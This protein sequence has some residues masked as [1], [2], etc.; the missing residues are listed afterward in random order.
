MRNEVIEAYVTDVLRR[1]PGKDRTGIGFELRGLLTDMLAEREHPDDDATVLAMLREFGT[2]AEVAERYRPPGLVII[3][4]SES[5]TFARWA[6][7]GVLLQWALTLPQVFGDLRL[8]TWWFSWGLGALWWPGFLVMAYL[9]QAAV[10]QRGW[11]TPSAW[12]P[13]TFDPERVNRG[14]L[15]MGL[16]AFA[17]GVAL[18]CALPWI[19]PALPAPLAQVLAF[20]ADFLRSRAWWALPLW[21]ASFATLAWVYARG[22][23]S[24]LTRHL[25][26]LTS[27]AFIALMA[28]WIAAGPI[29]LA[30]ATNDGARGA[31]VLVIAILLVDVVV[32]AVREAVR[33]RTPR[34]TTG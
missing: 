26:M 2:P 25:D 18:M 27:L 19:T 10:R 5:R 23:W 21:L 14:A 22:R 30:K 6:I 32:K 34:V 16:A 17:A 7:G 9:G 8:V 12:S 3:P 28:W 33:I 1:L 13:R 20:D 4:A 31:L 24:T 29:F 15:G 11:L